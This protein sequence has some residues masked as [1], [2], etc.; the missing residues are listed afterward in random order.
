MS[1]TK[2]TNLARRVLGPTAKVKRT[3][4]HYEITTH[5][6]RL[7]RQTAT[8]MAALLQEI[9]RARHYR[10]HGHMFHVAERYGAAGPGQG[11]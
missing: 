5:N 11:I 2:L 4:H 8:K 1:H 9:E 7:Y 3:G 10:D 6:S